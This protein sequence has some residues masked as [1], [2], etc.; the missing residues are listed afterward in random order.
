MSAPHFVGAHLTMLPVGIVINPKLRM[1]FLV[2]QL[3]T[4]DTDYRS[5]QPQNYQVDLLSLVD[6]IN[7]ARLV[8]EGNGSFDIGQLDESELYQLPA[9]ITGCPRVHTPGGVRTKQVGNG[10]ALYAGLCIAAHL[11]SLEEAFLYHLDEREPCIV[12]GYIA[13]AEAQ[14]WWQSAA[15][16]GLATWEHADDEDEQYDV[17]MRAGK[18]TREGIEADIAEDYPYSGSGRDEIDVHLRQVN[19]LNVDY[20]VT[21]SFQY[22]RLNFDMLTERGL[23]GFAST[24]RVLLKGW[25]MSLAGPTSSEPFSGD[26][27]IK[28]LLACDVRMCSS[29]M[30]ALIHGLLLEA[31]ATDEAQRWKVRCDERADPLPLEP[32]SEALKPNYRRNRGRGAAKL[33]DALEQA[34]AARDELG[35]GRLSDELTDF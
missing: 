22:G 14:H 5:R 12:G 33:E 3:V 26:V 31:D 13:S 10:T 27:H 15:R 24:E 19:A 34:Q 25:N 18:H 2:A 32:T 21:R 17:D 6:G 8:R 1:P 20:E 16:S 35:W 23:V 29:A 7:E 9:R 28:A 4:E 30:Q 11:A